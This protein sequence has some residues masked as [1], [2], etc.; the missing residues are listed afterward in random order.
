MSLTFPLIV[1]PAHAGTHHG[2]RSDAPEFAQK[3]VPA[4]AGMT[5]DLV[6]AAHG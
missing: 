4:C 5:R 3:W 2:A 1:I 6:S